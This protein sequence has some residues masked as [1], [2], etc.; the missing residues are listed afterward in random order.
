MLRVIL[1]ASIRIDVLGNPFDGIIR[2]NGWPS[3]MHNELNLVKLQSWVT[4]CVDLKDVAPQFSQGV[5]SFG[6]E[7]FVLPN[8][9]LETAVA[10]I[11]AAYHFDMLSDFTAL[12]S[13]NQAQN[14]WSIKAANS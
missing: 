6:V 2:P 8:E 3:L 10:I 7:V 14:P 13:R 1:F 5:R 12:I 4:F 11:L 9:P